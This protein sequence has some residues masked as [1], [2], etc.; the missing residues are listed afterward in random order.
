[1]SVLLVSN[2]PPFFSEDDDQTRT[3]RIIHAVE[4]YYLSELKRLLP[5]GPTDEPLNAKGMTLL[6]MVANHPPQHHML[7]WI[8]SFSLNVNVYTLDGATPL[9]L[10][11]THGGR[12]AVFA[13]RLIRYLLAQGA[14]VTH[15]TRTGMTALHFV[16]WYGWVEGVKLLLKAGADPNAHSVSGSF[17][18]D[19]FHYGVDARE[20]ALI[21]TLLNDARRERFVHGYGL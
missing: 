14:C 3:K 16:C 17:P 11:S 19:E 18:G 6:H 9:Y 4:Y 2:T 21:H 8:E 10:A 13:H 12:D 7:D 5:N 15:V 1:M 20:R